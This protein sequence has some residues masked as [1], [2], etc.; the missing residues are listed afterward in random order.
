M[1]RKENA[2]VYTKKAEHKTS[3]KDGCLEPRILECQ[4]INDLPTEA[5]EVSRKL[6][7]CRKVLW[8]IFPYLDVLDFRELSQ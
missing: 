8:K 5:R 3:Q 6:V 7:E 1:Y 2:A 4:S